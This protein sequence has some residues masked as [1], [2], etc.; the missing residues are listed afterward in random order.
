MLYFK[1]RYARRIEN[2][3]DMNHWFSRNKTRI[4]LLQTESNRQVMHLNI[5]LLKLKRIWFVTIMHHTCVH[6]YDIHNV[7]HLH[8]SWDNTRGVLYSL[9]EVTLYLKQNIYVF[10]TFPSA[11]NICKDLYKGYEFGMNTSTLRLMKQ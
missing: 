8:I 5:L 7:L 2:F 10:K 11:L 6:A 1:H 9:W 4:K 3:V